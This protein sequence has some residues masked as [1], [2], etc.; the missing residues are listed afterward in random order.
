VL[1]FPSWLKGQ[2]FPFLQY[3][4]ARNLHDTGFIGVHGVP[5]ALGPVAPG[6]R[7]KAE[8]AMMKSLRV[9]MIRGYMRWRSHGTSLQCLSVS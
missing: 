5:Q 4:C 2:E 7:E 3:P 8:L 6:L 9:E 1:V